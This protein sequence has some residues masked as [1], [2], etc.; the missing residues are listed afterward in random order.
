VPIPRIPSRSTSSD[1]VRFH[2]TGKGRHT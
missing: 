2:I 1:I